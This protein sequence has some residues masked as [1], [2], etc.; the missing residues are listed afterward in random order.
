MRDA[1]YEYA[2]EHPEEMRAVI[3]LIRRSEAI[4][5]S[6]K[7]RIREKLELIQRCR[8]ELEHETCN[9]RS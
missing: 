7:K 3:S 8:E 4:E 5:I 9:K 6:R 2:E 1:Y